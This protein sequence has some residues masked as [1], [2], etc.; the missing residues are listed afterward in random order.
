MIVWPK[1]FVLT[2]ICIRRNGYIHLTG[3]VTGDEV[4]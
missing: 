3:H 4:L 2:I 1:K